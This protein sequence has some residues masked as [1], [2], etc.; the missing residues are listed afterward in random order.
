MKTYKDIRTEM[1]MTQKE[2][3]DFLGMSKS[4]Y[5]LI[6]NYKRRFEVTKLISFLK[7]YKDKTGNDVDFFTELKVA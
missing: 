2:T 4:S 7:L 6:E 1:E 5:C 3:A